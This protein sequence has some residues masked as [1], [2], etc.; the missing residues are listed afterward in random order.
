MSTT[1]EHA[2]RRGSSSSSPRR[3]RG[4]RARTK[5]LAAALATA[6]VLFG[7][8]ATAEASSQSL[9]T[10]GFGLDLGLARSIL[11]EDGPSEMAVA[12]LSPEG[13]NILAHATISE[14]KTWTVPTLAGTVLYVRDQ[15]M[16]RAFD[17][18]SN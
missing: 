3:P 7:A 16:I 4:R 8:P 15:T 13:M 12:E 6:A 5:G 10:G 11:G 17:L 1:V 14:G 9:V 18:G 2:G